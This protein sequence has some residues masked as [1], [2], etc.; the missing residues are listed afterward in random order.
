[1]IFTNVEVV[2]TDKNF[3]YIEWELEPSPTTTAAPTTTIHPAGESIDDYKFQIHWAND[4]SSGFLPILGSDGLPIEIDGAV[5]PLSYNHQWNQYDFNQDRY[6]KIL[7]I[8]KATPTNNFFSEVVFIGMYF[9]GVQDTMRYAEDLLY[10]FYYGEPCVI[11]KRKSF[12]ARCPE[13]WMPERQQRSKSHCETCKGSGYIAG[14]YQPIRSQMAYDSDPKKADTQKEWSNP[15]DSKRAR[16]SNYPLVQPGDLIF[17]L[18]DNKRYV[19]MHVETTKLPKLSESAV[20]L[21]KQNYIVSQ[22]LSLE[23]LNTSDNEYNIDIENIPEIPIGDE[24]ETGGIVPGYVNKRYYGSNAETSL[25][26]SEILALNKENCTE[27]A[28]T[29]DYDCTGGKYIWICY[30]SRFGTARF[31]VGGFETTFDLTVKSVTNEEAYTETYNCYKSFRLQHN[32]TITV[33]VI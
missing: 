31:R 2:K 19:I 3:Y 23:E 1:M 33:A 26:N 7:A 4:P 13:C 21:S 17:N 8:E 16:I 18:D 15:F 11:I 22:M 28:N 10:N 32:D 14:F 30:P 27:K 24:G 6:Y 12:G 9:D 20:I 25:S 29:H 5:G